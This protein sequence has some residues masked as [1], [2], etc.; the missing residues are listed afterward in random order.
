MNLHKLK[1]WCSKQQPS[2]YPDPCDS[3]RRL[4]LAIVSVLHRSRDN[5]KSVGLDH[6]AIASGSSQY[7][8][9]AHFLWLSRVQTVF[10]QVSGL[11]CYISLSCRNLVVV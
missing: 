8:A 11:P 1:K 4:S 5:A 6:P 2:P 7:E 10:G 3:D 9:L